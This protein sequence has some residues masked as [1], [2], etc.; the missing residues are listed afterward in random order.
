ML[1]YE[2]LAEN[3]HYRGWWRRAVE[4]NEK[5]EALALETHSGERYGW[6]HFRG[7][8]LYQLGRLHEALELCRRG[9]EHCRWT[10]DRRLELFL[11]GC[12]AL[13]LTDTGDVSAGVQ[14]ARRAVREADELNLVGHRIKLA[15]FLS[16][17]LMRQGRFDEA[18]AASLKGVEAWRASGSKGAG[19]IHGAGLAERLLLGGMEEEASDALDAHLVLAEAAKARNGI[20][21]NL[22]VRALLHARE[23]LQSE[24]LAA[25]GEAIVE[26][27][28]CESVI[29]LV[30]ALV[31]RA[32][33]LRKAGRDA[34][35]ELDI[36]RAKTILSASGATQDILAHG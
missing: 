31:E 30:R 29:E 18:A 36:A 9:I 33:L 10:G 25:L 4:F 13:C 17:V 35:S 26:L 15:D 14:Q 7:F 12:Y 34:D 2:F 11:R 1:G 24:A 16:Y 27:E 22:R 8:S 6:A 19:L 20:A 28:A 21:Q 32:R 23:G 5:E 3:S